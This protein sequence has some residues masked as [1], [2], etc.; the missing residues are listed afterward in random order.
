MTTL[1]L[2]EHRVDD[3]RARLGTSEASCSLSPSL[4]VGQP[5]SDG[6]RQGRSVNIRYQ[7]I[8]RHCIKGSR[9]VYGHTHSFMLLYA[10]GKNGVNLS[11]HQ[12]L[13]VSGRVLKQCYLHNIMDADCKCIYYCYL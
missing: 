8:M 9:Q 5:W 10:N 4:V 3:S 2:E 6:G 1:I 13:I 11:G 7:C 12:I